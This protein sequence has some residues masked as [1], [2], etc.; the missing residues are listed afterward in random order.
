MLKNIL[1]LKEEKIKKQEE[2][3]PKFRKMH[4]ENKAKVLDELQQRKK[5]IEEFTS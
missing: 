1:K 2:N 3:K 4:M 5:E